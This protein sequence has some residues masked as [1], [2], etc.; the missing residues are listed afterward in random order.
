LAVRRAVE[1]VPH[2]LARVAAV[3]REAGVGIARRPPDRILRAEGTAAARRAVV[4][5]RALR[6]AA[7]PQR[8]RV[9]RRRAVGRVRP[10]V[11]WSRWTSFISAEVN[12]RRPSIGGADANPVAE[13]IEVVSV[14]A[15]EPVLRAWGVLRR[16][17]RRAIGRAGKDASVQRGALGRLADRSGL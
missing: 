16:F 9:A 7:L 3:L 6:R 1:A 17:R 11:G 10:H 14:L 5:A 8:D 13:R 4:V 15:E 12:R 2:D